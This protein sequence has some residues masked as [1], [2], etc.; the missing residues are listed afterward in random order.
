M[1]RVFRKSKNEK[2]L[3]AV[4][5]VEIV[6]I[7]AILGIL[8]V[9]GAAAIIN[10]HRT[11]VMDAEL[12]T[13]TA[14]LQRARQLAISNG[15]GEDYSIIFLA[16]SYVIFPGTSYSVSDPDNDVHTLAS[17]VLVSSSYTNDTVTFQNF[18]GRTGVAGSTTFS[19]FGL[20]KTITVNALG[21]VEDIS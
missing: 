21:I 9:T 14:R 1:L 16:D 20:T 4:T 12:R 10:Y 7:T 11:S 6:L 2:Q 17:N 18:T 3:P 13:I 5:L 8:S 19:A 15:T